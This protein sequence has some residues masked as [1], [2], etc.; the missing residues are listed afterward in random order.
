M[1]RSGLN[2]DEVLG[3]PGLAQGEVHDRLLSAMAADGDYQAVQVSPDRFHFARTFRPTW[4]IVTACLTVWIALLGIVFLLVKTTETCLAVIES[5][6]RGVRV[7]LQGR[8]SAA[9]MGRLRAALSGE[10]AFSPSETAAP[11]PM[12][13]PGSP[14]PTVA[15]ARPA[16]AP[17]ASTFPTVE[18]RGQS[19]SVGAAALPQPPAPAPAVPAPVSG[20]APTTAAQHGVVI[21]PPPQQQPQQGQRPPV[22]A[23]GEAP[24]PF[25][26]VAQASP[27][28]AGAPTWVSPAE[29]AGNRSSPVDGAPTDHA[30]ERTVASRPDR[31]GAMHA[32]SGPRAVIDDGSVIELAAITLIGRDPAAAGGEQA[33]LVRVDDSTRSVSKT[34]LAIVCDDGRWTVVDRN[35]TNGVSISGA[36]GGDAVPLT[37]GV[38]TP[39]GDRAVVRFGDRSLR[40][41]LADAMSAVTAVT[42]GVDR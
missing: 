23:R 1:A 31:S 19:R 26:G 17:V 14:V 34:H 35:S 12:R 41:E 8:I 24:P 22:Q 18:G 30:D 10:A 42:D 40:V 7:R 6:H 15:P 29:P 37:P 16:G 36:D 39:L 32:P 38:P 13:M 21:P 11:Q 5:D 2:V 28:V 3:A 4:A 20:Q 25:N 9:A 33:L 27:A